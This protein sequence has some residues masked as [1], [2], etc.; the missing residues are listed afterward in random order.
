MDRSDHSE[1]EPSRAFLF[2]EHPDHPGW[3]HWR[4]PD[5]T[6]FNSFLGDVIVRQEDALARVRMTPAHRH[7]NFGNNV[8]GGALLGFIDVALFAALRSF[9]VLSAG[10]AVTL[11]LNTHFIGAG[12]VGEPLEAQ[13]EILRETRRLIFVRGLLLQMEMIVAEFSGT[14]RKPSAG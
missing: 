10:P 1:A 4:F 8:H 5:D 14:I 2:D 13:V 3:M 12:R 9:G 7:S 11:D 6:R